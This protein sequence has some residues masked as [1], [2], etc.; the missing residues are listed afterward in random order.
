MCAQD[1]APG[2]ALV[3]HGQ[4]ILSEADA[5]VW[6]HAPCFMLQLR[7]CLRAIETCTK[8][9]YQAWT[10]GRCSLMR[11]QPSTGDK[12]SLS[13]NKG[14]LHTQD[15]FHGTVQVASTA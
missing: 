9:G 13:A 1:P 8:A 3:S 5:V 12:D 15:H 6:L 11:D 10:R 2:N 14:M 4:G 7:A